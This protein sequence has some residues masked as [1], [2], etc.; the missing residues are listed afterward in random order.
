MNRNKP[1]KRISRRTGLDRRWI[2]SVN[3]QPERRR[4]RDRRTIRHRSF[5]EPI[6]LNGA[7]ENSE[8]F[9]EINIQTKQLEAKNAALPLDEKGFSVAREAVFKRVTSDNG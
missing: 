7:A 5:L 9:P 4:S 2:P 3:H 8:R 1:S 6:E